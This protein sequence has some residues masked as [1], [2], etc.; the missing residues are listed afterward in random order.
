MANEDEASND[1]YGGRRGVMELSA[2]DVVLA[3]NKLLS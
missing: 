2:Q 1:L 3:Q